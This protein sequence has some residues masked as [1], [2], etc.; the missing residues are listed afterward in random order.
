ME[1]NTHLMFP[2]ALHIFDHKMKQEEQQIMIDYINGTRNKETTDVSGLSKHTKNNLHK[3]PEFESLKNTINEAT[4]EV[5]KKME[6]KCNSLEMTGMWGNALPKGN[7][8]AP[9]THSNHLFSGVFY[10]KSDELSSP[11][12]FFDPRPQAHVMRPDKHKDNTLNSDIVAIPCN[13]GVG[14]IFPS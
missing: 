12:Q 1:I 9:H 3:I 11:I 14:I 13:T 2:T 8:H 6:F 7:A 4:Q 10:V 5:V